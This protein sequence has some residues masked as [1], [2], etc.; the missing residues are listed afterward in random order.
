MDNND[1]LANLKRD[2]VE[3]N[4]VTIVVPNRFSF[5]EHGTYDFDSFVNFF[6]W[7]YED[8]KVKIDLTQCHNA[9]YQAFSLLVLY[10]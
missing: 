7:S 10:A 2:L 3:T 5:M 9:N 4:T 6:N 1:V 8:Q